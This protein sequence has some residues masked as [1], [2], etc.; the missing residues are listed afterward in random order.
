MGGGR[1]GGGWWLFEERNHL[2][3][4]G[5]FCHLR[6]S[7]F[8][9]CS[10]MLCVKSSWQQSHGIVVSPPYLASLRME[11]SLLSLQPQYVFAE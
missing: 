6:L 5:S 8:L 1:V 4:S 9:L 3:L 2:S 11:A 7:P 10:I